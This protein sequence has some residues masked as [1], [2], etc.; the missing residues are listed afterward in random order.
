MV[1]KDD[2]LLIMGEIELNYVSFFPRNRLWLHRSKFYFKKQE[3]KLITHVYM[4]LDK[5]PNITF[6]YLFSELFIKG[7]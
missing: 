1:P 3:Q 4:F 5:R 7:P 6:L 2:E